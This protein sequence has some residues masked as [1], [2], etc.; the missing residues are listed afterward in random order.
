MSEASPAAQSEMPKLR[1]GLGVIVTKALAVFVLRLPKVLLLS[2]P[3]SIALGL[4]FYAAIEWL[5]SSFIRHAL[6]LPWW[7]LNPFTIFSV[8]LGLASGLM[9][10]PL[11]AAFQAFDKTGVLPLGSSFRSLKAKPF[12]AMIVGIIVVGATLLPFAML[13]WATSARLGL[14]IGCVALAVGMYG[15]ALWGLA[16]PAISRD[17][18]GFRALRRSMELSKGYRWRIAGTCFVLFFMALLAGGVI[19]AGLVLLGRIIMFEL[20]GLPHFIEIF[21]SMDLLAVL[22]FLDFCL[23]FTIIIAV[24]MLGLAAIRAR[25][26]EIKEAPDIEDMIDIFD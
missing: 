14:F 3:A 4:L 26:V 22:I 15:M 18:M 23:G 1:L 17:G 9:A 16:L 13:S 8:G 20:L 25:M 10:G 19:G 21:G 6:L 24:N 5:Q 7:M 11:S 2:L 12:V